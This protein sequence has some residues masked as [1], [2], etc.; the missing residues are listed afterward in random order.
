MGSPEHSCGVPVAAIR[1]EPDD[2]AEQVT[3]ALRGEPLTVETAGGGWAR[4]RTA[5]GY[6]GWVRE[7]A[8][9]EATGAAWPLAGDF[10]DAVAAARSYTGAPYLW[11]GM[12]HA[13]IDCSGLVH[14]A[15]R[16][17][18][19]LVPRDADQQEDAGLDDGDPGA[20]TLLT[21]GDDCGAAATH[22]AFWLGDGR[23]LHA[24]GG[25]GRVLEE[26]EP[27][28]LLPRRRRFFR[29]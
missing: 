5:Y 7:E 20:V 3:Q 6:P 13:G 25:A 9:G 28:H 14:M 24:S 26:P 8:L 15:Y 19:R 29:L 23:I 10:D 18:G 4:V 21:Y 1:A 27:A 16:H 22:I 12:T 17:L 2:A 11:G